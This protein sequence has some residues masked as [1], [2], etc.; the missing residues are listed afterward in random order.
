MGALFRLA[1]AMG[2][3]QLF[4]CGQTPAP[5]HRR[6]GKTARSSEQFVPFSWQESAETVLVQLKKENYQLVG[7]EITDQSSPLSA[8]DFTSWPATALVIGSENQG[9]LPETLAL[10]DCT[11]HIPMYGRNTSMNVVQACGIALYGIT[12]QLLRNAGK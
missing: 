2:V 3:Q 5:P 11:V 1:D 10:L 12:Q 6:I 4:L 8:L 7:L 9:I